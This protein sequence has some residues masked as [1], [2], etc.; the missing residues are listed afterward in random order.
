MALLIHE[1]QLKGRALDEYVLLPVD[2][3]LR[4]DALLK[5]F[6]MTEEGFE[7]RFHLCRSE[8]GETLVQF[9]VRL[10]GYLQRWL[11]MAKT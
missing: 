8:I 4:Y 9:S 7:R 11:E 3:A 1:R 5:R 10:S 2:Q 6:D